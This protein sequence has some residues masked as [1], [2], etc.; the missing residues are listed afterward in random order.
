MKLKNKKNKRA[1]TGSIITIF[2]ATIMIIIILILFIAISY[3]FRT[4]IKAGTNLE[5][6]GP[7]FGSAGSDAP[8]YKEYWKI[9]NSIKDI[10]TLK[11]SLNC[12]GE[13]N[14]EE[15]SLHD[16]LA[17]WEGTNTEEI[18]NFIVDNKCGGSSI[19]FF[20]IEI[21]KYLL[22][23]TEKFCEIKETPKDSKNMQCKIGDESV[24]INLELSPSNI[25]TSVSNMGIIEFS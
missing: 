15:K 2:V 25:K 7:S 17:L 4:E 12:E 13:F 8:Y 14:N 9:H 20:N 6:V 21:S 10:T 5:R 1:L 23:T 24:G 19:A 22:C 16:V 3:P 18:N 11:Y